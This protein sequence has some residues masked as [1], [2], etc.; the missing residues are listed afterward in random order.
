MSRLTRVLALSVAAGAAF[1]TPATANHTPCAGMGGQPITGI[2][3]TNAT[4]CYYAGVNGIAV[5]TD[6]I[7]ECDSTCTLGGAHAEYTGGTNL[8]ACVS[9]I[10]EGTWIV[11]NRCV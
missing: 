4:L 10:Y 11:N 5:G 7:H 6:V 2:G 9:V 1:A 8:N 3:P